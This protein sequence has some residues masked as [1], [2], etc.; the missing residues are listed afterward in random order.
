LFEIRK[1]PE[2]IVCLTEEP[3]EILY[4][5]GEQERIVGITTYTKRPPEAE[6][7]KPKV[8]AFLDAHMK[9]IEDLKPD[10]LIGF[11]DIQG[12]LARKLIEKNHQVLIFN[13][14]SLQEILDVILVIGTLVDARDKALAWLGETIENL[15]RTKKRFK[16]KEKP[17]VYFE[18]W[19]DPMISG[20][21]WVSELIEL[22]GGEDI[23]SDLSKGKNAKDRFVSKEQVI[24]KDPQV[25]IGSWCG[26]PVD[27]QLIRQREG[28][29]DI[30]AVQKQRIYEIDSTD[31][32]QPGPACLTDGLSKLIECIH[33]EKS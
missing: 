3:C 6:K 13:Q 15:E 20:I 33:G 27:I 5:L 25:I 2:R 12:P 21:R 14:R 28:W 26:K 9:K 16:K 32:L 31:I 1:K 22:A 7:E 17:R 30:A 4:L 10:L 23:F 18:E 11:S 19:D 29:D 8:S 24:E